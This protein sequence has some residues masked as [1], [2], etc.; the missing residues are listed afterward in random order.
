MLIN[1]MIKV[2][3]ALIGVCAVTAMLFAW[4]YFVCQEIESIALL[5]KMTW[6]IIVAAIPI[7]LLIFVVLVYVF[8]MA[9]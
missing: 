1:S 9:K 2:I 4:V 6:S 3:A 8:Y 7:L 5:V